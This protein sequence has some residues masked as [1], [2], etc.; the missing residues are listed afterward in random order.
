MIRSAL[1]IAL[2]AL[3]V[4]PA[5]GSQQAPLTVQEKISEIATGSIV[6]VKT[7]LK[8]MKRVRGRL[9]SVS[10][11]GFEI[12]T[13]KGQKIDNVKLSFDDVKSVAEKPTEKGT[14]PAIWILAGVGVALTV[15][16]VVAVA[17]A[18]AD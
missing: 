18:G 2:C 1:A 5:Q 13:G 14:H 4:L 10:N 6:E 3:M 12:Q 17:A 15:L 11:D 9:V 16:L 8:N 7:K